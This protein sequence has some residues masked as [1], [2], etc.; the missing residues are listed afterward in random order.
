MDRLKGKIAIITGVA[1]KASIGFGIAKKLAEE[2]SIVQIIDIQPRVLKRAKDLVES[3]KKANAYIA[4]LINKSEVI[5]IVN[6][7]LYSSYS[8]QDMTA[9]HASSPAK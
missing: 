2:G 7:I 5:E 8:K 4:D 6:K 9:S 3:G 1:N